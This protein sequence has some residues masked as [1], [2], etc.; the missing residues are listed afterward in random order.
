M[1]LKAALGLIPRPRPAQLPEAELS[2]VVRVDPDHLA[3]YQRVCG[4]RRDTRLPCAYPHILAFDL[5]MDLMTRN[6]FPFPVVGLVHIANRIEQAHALTA[7]DEVTITVKTQNLRDHPRGK[8]FDIV[9]TTA[10]GWQ[11]VSTYLKITKQGEKE[12]REKTEPPV[13]H[14]IW[15]F[16]ESKSYA[17]VSGDHNPIHTSV[18]GARLFGFPRPI[19][20]GMF[21]MARCLGALEPRLPDQLIVD[22][23]FKLPVLLPAKTAFRYSHNEFTLTDRK[24][25]KPHLSGR[26]SA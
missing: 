23:S 12:P 19:A 24:T 26:I 18:I 15:R 21:T 7:D 13:P 8:Q 11:E 1:Y 14:A 25:G 20:H 4:Y 9:T 3:D 10:Q 5:Q 17:R 22:V 16:T 6:D 2:K